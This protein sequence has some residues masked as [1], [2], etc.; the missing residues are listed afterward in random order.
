MKA[1]FAVNAW[2]GFAVGNTMPWPRNTVDLQRFRKLTTGATVVMGRGTWDSDMPKP[3]P[4]RKNIVLSKTLVD[5]RCI[6]CDTISQLLEEVKNDTNVWVIGGVQT[7]WELR[8]H[9]TNV[10]MTRFHYKDR[11]DI[12]LDTDKYLQ[13]YELI[14]KEFHSDHTFKVY[15]RIQ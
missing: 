2:D 5:D 8:P 12:T 13:D 9:V 11:A 7:L 4:N 3:L 10:Y 1:I 15:R 14:D 6:V